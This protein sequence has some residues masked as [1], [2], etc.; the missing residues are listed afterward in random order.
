MTADD[1]TS[2]DAASHDATAHHTTAHDAIAQDATAALA[3]LSPMR[4]SAAKMSYFCLLPHDG[5]P[6]LRGYSTKA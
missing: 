1:A 6:W 5:S 4:T 2:H 3:D